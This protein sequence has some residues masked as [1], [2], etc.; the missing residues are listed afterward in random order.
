MT[1]PITR[2]IRATRAITQSAAIH[3]IVRAGLVVASVM[4]QNAP[5]VIVKMWGAFITVP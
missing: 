3:P 5:N 4:V 1:A 2:I